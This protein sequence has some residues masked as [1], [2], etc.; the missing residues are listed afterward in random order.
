MNHFYKILCILCLC[1][2]QISAQQNISVKADKAALRQVVKLVEAQ[3]P[4][5]FLYDEQRI[6]L[7]KRISLDVTGNLNSVLKAIEKAAFVELQV[8]GKHI[9]MKPSRTG[10]LSGRV[11]DEQGAPL[12]SVSVY[13]PA[14][15]QRFITGENGEFRFHYPATKTRNELLTISLLGRQEQRLQVDL[16]PGERRLPDVILPILSM[17]LEE[18]SVAPTADSRLESNSSIY[19]NREVILQSGALSL[20]DLLNL[21]PG[22]K[23]EAPSLQRVQQANLRT[24]NYATNSAASRDAF[25]LNNAFGVALILDGIA[26]SNNANMQTRNVGM[27]GMENA[28]VFGGASGLTGGGNSPGNYSGDYAFGGLDLRQITTDNIESVEIVAGVASAR[29]GDLTD[30]AIIINRMAGSSPLHFQM[31]L[32]DNATVY[33]MNKGFQTKK[34]GGFSFGANFTRSFEDNRD[35]LKAY[36]RWGGNAMWTIAGG[37]ERAFTNTLSVDYNRNLDNILQD[38]DDPTGTF[39]RFRTYNFSIANR[40]NYRIDHGFISN[41]GLNMRYGQSYQNTYKE[42]LMNGTFVIYSDATEVGVAQGIYGP[43]TY[44]S[45]SHIEGK[46]IDFTTR[47]DLTGRY[48]TG[49]V[50]HQVQF[51]ANYNYSK[52][53]GAGQIV[54]PSRPNSLASAA[55][56]SNRSARYYDYTQIRAQHQ[57]GLYAEDV[58]QLDVADRPLHVRAGARMDFFEKF[59]TVSPRANLRYELNSK[60]RVG[61]AYGFSSKAPALAQLYPGPVYY[62]IPLFQYTAVTETGAVDAAKSLYLLHVDK[63]VPGNSTLKPSKSQQFELSTMYASNG[64]R[65]AINVYDK[66]N[67]DGIGTVRGFSQVLLDRYERNPDQTA[68][69]PYIINGTDLRRLTRNE[70]RNGNKSYNRGIEV[71]L[72]TPKWEAIQTV[73][74]LRG[75]FTH[76]EARPLTSYNFLDFTNPGTDP[77]YAVTGVYPSRLRVTMTSNA[78]LTTSTHIPKAKLIVNFTA[79]FNILNETKTLATD[80]IPVGYYTENGNYYLINEFDPENVQYRHLLQ[81]QQLLNNQNQPGLYSNFHLNLSKEIT[82]RLTVS[83]NVYNVFNY[84]PQYLRSDNTLIIPNSKPTYGAQLRLRL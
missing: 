59:V 26:L 43:G 50:A 32:R 71:L 8:S 54:D 52:N 81:T 48:Y 75:G 77:G 17:G 39:V 7:N 70:F 33:G 67:Y 12:Q 79:E 30:G 80:G 1:T 35:K 20:N 21:V 28:G 5:T 65:L 4:Y 56:A 2:N 14:M 57:I 11:I 34:F 29:Y 62:E 36:D 84:R 38:P 72:S 66:R 22:K 53:N 45:I 6:S 60:W 49:D 40:A 10:L 24:A 42:Q 69:I 19:I 46:P 73:F 27:T 63:F 15:D 3:V 44:T 58:F 55:T 61:L 16:E 18:V 25:A 23:I 51:G 78:A 64:Y 41:I 13:L 76:T 74:N 82:E 83:F 31:Q 68:E 37:R 47:L 9:L